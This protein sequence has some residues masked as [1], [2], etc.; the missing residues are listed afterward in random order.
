MAATTY[1]ATSRT[2]NIAERCGTHRGNDGNDLHRS[3]KRNAGNKIDK[4][5]KQ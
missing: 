5:I 2:Y 3:A 1:R 4:T